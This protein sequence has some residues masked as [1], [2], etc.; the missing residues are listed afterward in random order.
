MAPRPRRRRYR[1]GAGTAP[2]SRR[3]GLLADRL[4]RPRER[5]ALGIGPEG[6]PLDPDELDI[7]HAEE[8]QNT[9]QISDR[10][11]ERLRRPLRED[12]AGGDDQKDLLAA[13]EPLW[14]FR[15][16]AEG[17]SGPGHMVQPRFQ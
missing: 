8:A 7:G 14:P 17:Q 16:V 13:H 9:F 1:A 12:A 5:R 3:D 11:V 6:N 10:V 4:L 2:D 15:G